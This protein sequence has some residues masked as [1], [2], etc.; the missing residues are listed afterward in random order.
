MKKTIIALTVCTTL[1]ACN[2]N[3]N[4]DPKPVETPKSVETPK[5]AEAAAS[6]LELPANY[7]ELIAGTWVMRTDGGNATYY[8]NDVFVF[9]SGNA[10]KLKA[11]NRRETVSQ[12]PAAP[13]KSTVSIESQDNGTYAVDKD[14]AEIIF[15]FNDAISKQDVEHTY[16]IISISDTEMKLVLTN[17]FEQN[18][19]IYKKEKK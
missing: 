6:V 8:Y 7:K 16:K 10:D 1:F 11:D 13:K 15:S 19:L 18:V 3:K 14:K 17:A 5:P 4:A 12:D 2:N 9:A